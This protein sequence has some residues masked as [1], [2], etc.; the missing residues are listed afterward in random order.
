MLLAADFSRAGPVACGVGVVWGQLGVA[1][2]SSLRN[3]GFG[4]LALILHLSA[5]RREER[6]VCRWMC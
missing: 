6:L 2:S 4:V 1:A 3:V 5:D